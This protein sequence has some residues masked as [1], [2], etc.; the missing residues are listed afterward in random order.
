MTGVVFAGPSL[1][2]SVRPRVTGLEWRPP[3]RQGDLYLAALQGSTLIGVIDGY[4]EL[5]PTVWHKEILWAMAHGIAS[6]FIGRNDGSRRKL[7]MTPE[8]LLEAGLLVYFQ[9]LGLAGG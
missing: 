6:L 8:E 2:P 4:F 9:S 5:V 1:P 7:P 3:V